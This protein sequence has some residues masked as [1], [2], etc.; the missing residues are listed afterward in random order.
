M[1][2]SKLINVSKSA[3]AHYLNGWRGCNHLTSKWTYECHQVPHLAPR[4]PDLLSHCG[5][6]LTM[7][8]A[9]LQESHDEYY[10]AG[11]LNGLIETI[12]ENCIVDVLRETGSFS[13]IC[14]VRHSIKFLPWIRHKFMEFELELVAR[15]RKTTGF[16]ESVHRLSAAVKGF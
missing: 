10:T 5:Q 13:L 2:G 15:T 6:S 16:G 11:S 14:K 1:L 7:K 4:I 8:C 9:V 3:A 12:P